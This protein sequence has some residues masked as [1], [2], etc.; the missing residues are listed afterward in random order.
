MA[1]APA[2]IPARAHAQEQPAAQQATQ[3][4]T[5]AVDAKPSQEEQEQAFLNSK[6]VQKVADLL[7]IQEPVARTILLTLNFAIIFFA[8]AIP[9][10]KVMPKV[11]RK[12]SQNLRH[13]LDEARKASDEA[14]QRMSAVEAK[15]AGLD[16]E[17]AA[18]RA[19]I[20]QDSLEDEKRIKASLKEESERIVTSAEQEINAAALHARRTLQSFAADL[21]IENAARQLKLTPETDRALI[22]EF[23]GQVAGGAGNAK[24]GTK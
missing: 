23:I 10:A 2:M 12:R 18:Y 4:K 24:G 7:H 3:E 19:Q 13:E 8:V 22:S 1:I 11:F 15:L 16:H 21:A 5:A 6:N 9:L 14:R 20:E 17:I